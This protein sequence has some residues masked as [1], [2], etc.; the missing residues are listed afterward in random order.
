MSKKLFP[1]AFWAY[2][3]YAVVGIDDQAMLTNLDL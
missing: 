3:V 2:P 1:D